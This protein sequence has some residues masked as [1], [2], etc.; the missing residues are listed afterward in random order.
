MF[1]HPFLLD[2]ALNPENANNPPMTDLERLVVGI[3]GLGYTFISLD[4]F[5]STNATPKANPIIDLGK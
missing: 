3:K 1:Y 2:P 5:V 4:N